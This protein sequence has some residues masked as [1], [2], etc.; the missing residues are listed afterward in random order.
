M[1]LVIA[2]EELEMRLGDEAKGGCP[3]HSIVCRLYEFE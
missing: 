1:E 3:A 2:V